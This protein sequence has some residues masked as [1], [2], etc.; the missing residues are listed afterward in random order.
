MKFSFADLFIE[1][2]L[3]PFIR[4]GTNVEH[5]NHN[6]SSVTWSMSGNA[7]GLSLVCLRFVGGV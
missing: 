1:A 4:H 5:N 7:V 3:K 6:M 2:S